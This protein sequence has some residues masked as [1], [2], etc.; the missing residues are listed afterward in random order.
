MTTLD[1]TP[2]SFL[3]PG[4]RTGMVL[5]Y[6][7]RSLTEMLGN[8]NLKAYLKNLRK[9]IVSRVDAN[10]RPLPDGERLMLVGASRS[11]KTLSVKLLIR[12]L[13]CQVADESNDW[14]AC[15]GTCPTCADRPHLYESSGLF[16]YFAA[17]NAGS[18]A[19][20]VVQTFPIDAANL[21]GPDEFRKT[22]SRIKQATWNEEDLVVVFIDESHRL[23]RRQ[24]DDMIL[25]V[26]EDV[27]ALWIMATAEPKEIEQMAMNRFSIV[28]TQP[29]T[30]AEVE[31]WL[32]DLCDA[33][34]I[35]WEPEAIMRVAEK[36]N[37]VPGRAMLALALAQRLGNHLTL[38][39]VDHKWK[40]TA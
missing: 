25:K 23:V 37:R 19:R 20:A 40:L 5:N 4:S 29:P 32:S 9:D 10:E 3:T 2:P 34:S 28:E 27:P 24:M 17:R 11:G 36:S 22:L 18:R 33:Y 31:A 13:T 1:S 14:T 15:G 21:A 12:S 7:P 6:Q 16:A 39:V 30:S 35:K 38:D 8:H 26:S